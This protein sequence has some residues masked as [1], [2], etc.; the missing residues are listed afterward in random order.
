MRLCRGRKSRS[1]RHR[2]RRI[3]GKACRIGGGRD[4]PSR[5]AADGASVRQHPR[6]GYQ[7]SR[8]CG[9]YVNGVADR[10]RQRKISPHSSG[11]PH[12]FGRKR[13]V[14]RPSPLGIVAGDFALAGGHGLIAISFVAGALKPC[15]GLHKSVLRG[16][17]FLHWV[18]NPDVNEF[19]IGFKPSSRNGFALL[20]QAF[21]PTRFGD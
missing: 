14:M 4:P 20:N 2:N 6:P 18:S 5:R 9:E 15:A 12:L 21:G 10:T 3:G 13:H 8:R 17:S 11:V 7:A 1:D 16:N 19:Y